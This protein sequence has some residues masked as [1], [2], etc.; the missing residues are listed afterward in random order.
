M[1]SKSALWSIEWQGASSSTRKWT[2]VL[3]QSRNQGWPWGFS[4]KGS[5]HG[6]LYCSKDSWTGLG[7]C[8]PEK[9]T[10]TFWSGWGG[11]LGRENLVFSFWKNLEALARYLCG[12]QK[13]EW[14]VEEMAEITA[15]MEDL[16]GVS[17]EIG[18]VR[19]GWWC[20]L[21]KGIIFC[22]MIQETKTSPGQGLRAADSEAAP[23]MRAKIWIITTHREITCWTQ[24][25]GEGRNSCVCFTVGKPRH[26]NHDSFCYG[27]MFCCTDAP[28]DSRRGF[29]LPTRPYLGIWFLSQ[30]LQWNQ[31]LNPANLCLRYSS[32]LCLSVFSHNLAWQSRCL[33]PAKNHQSPA[34][35]SCSWQF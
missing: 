5:G 26:R 3:M 28:T 17:Q 15:F 21:W 2:G 22:C 10:E 25:T 14:G 24:G 7:L 16:N 1:S 20:T 23:G 30:H 31:A 35:S 19:D 9:T 11:Q 33:I 13:K 12:K 6:S 34:G 29:L 32:P 27:W 4:G 8:Q 18:T